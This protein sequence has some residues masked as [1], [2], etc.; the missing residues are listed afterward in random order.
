MQNVKGTTDYYGKEQT[1]R[2]RI[3]RMMRETFE[4]YDYEEMDTAILNEMTLLTAKYSGGDE[5]VQEMY[6]LS[7]RG[8]RR[9][10][11]RYDLTV[12]LAKVVALQPGLAMPLRRYEFGKVFRDGPVKRGRMREFMQCDVD[13][14]GIRG[15]EAE[16]ELMQLAADVY[17]MLGIDVVLRWN[18]RRFLSEWLQAAGVPSGSANAAM[19]AI[20]KLAKAGIDAVRAELLAKGIDKQAVE[21]V[22]ADLHLPD[23][24][25]ALGA[26][27]FE[28]FERLCGKYG[29]GGLPGAEEV[30]ALQSLLAAIGLDGRC[31]FDPSLTR[32]LSFYTGTVYEAF[33]ASGDY[34]SS[35]GGGGRYD[36][37]IGQ[38]A[39]SPSDAGSVAVGLSF[40]LEPIM[41]LLQGRMEQPS[42]APVTVIPI[43][44]ATAAAMKAAA[45]VRSCGIRTRL[46]PA[47]RKL[48]KALASAAA[49]G[50][51]FVILVGEEEVS[52]GTVKLKDMASMNETVMDIEEAIFRIEQSQ[53]LPFR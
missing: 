7:D 51:R 18:N 41:E 15:P 33:D 19:L 35:L 6:G 20:D 40:G 31:R 17:G 9:L 22:L 10:G 29:I 27:S 4:R 11:L 32:G 12:P 42:S 53:S 21:A 52:T 14:V 49:G 45:A 5:I 28:S 25:N 1:M 43:G 36:A 3:R 46:S 37:I 8:E 44:S 16:A 13:V 30:R 2:S 34:A 38:L 39:G 50:T 48:R 47:G 26:V 23:D 24:G